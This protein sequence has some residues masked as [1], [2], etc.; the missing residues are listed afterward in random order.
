MRGIT[1]VDLHLVGVGLGISQ[2]VEKVPIN[3]DTLGVS[4]RV[5]V[6]NPQKIDATLIRKVLKKFDDLR[7]HH[8][9][10]FLVDSWAECVPIE[11]FVCL[12]IDFSILRLPHQSDENLHELG[13]LLKIIS[14]D[15]KLK[16]H[17]HF[18]RLVGRK[19]EGNQS[20][21][22]DFFEMDTCIFQDREK[23]RFPGLLLGTEHHKKVK[24]V[25]VRSE[26]DGHVILD[27]FLLP[28]VELEEVRTSSVALEEGVGYFETLVVL[29]RL[30]FSRKHSRIP[31][32]LLQI[33]GIILI[34]AIFSADLFYLST[35]TNS[36]NYN[37]CEK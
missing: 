21:L 11:R 26:A 33:Q 9:R 2:S 37:N 15:R 32:S 13:S 30:I 34:M 7:I 28:L 6:P 14:L 3:L 19:I 29:D 31:L 5:E 27:Q 10:F 17:Q 1:Y 20:L 23:V 4:V 12:G 24:V 16:S 36:E 18:L 35:R 22:A 25:V 8:R